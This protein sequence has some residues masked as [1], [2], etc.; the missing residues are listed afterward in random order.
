MINKGDKTS[1][2][3]QAPYNQA[4]PDDKFD[5]VL[6]VEADIAGIWAHLEHQAT[7]ILDIRVADG[8]SRLF[9]HYDHEEV[10]APA[11]GYMLENRHIRGAM[12]KAL[13]EEVLAGK[14]NVYMYLLA[15]SRIDD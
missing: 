2:F 3:K 13:G 5:A 14:P 11:L 6:N 4:N 10:G 15:S 12:T 8:N 1:S 7:P 9:L